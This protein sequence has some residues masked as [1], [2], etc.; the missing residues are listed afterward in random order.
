MPCRTSRQRTIRIEPV[1]GLFLIKSQHSSDVPI[2]SVSLRNF[3]RPFTFRA[4]LGIE[5]TPTASL[6][7]ISQFVGIFF[8]TKTRPRETENLSKNKKKNL[9]ASIRI[10]ITECM[11]ILIFFYENMFISCSPS[12]EKGYYSFVSAY[13]S[14]RWK[15]LYLFVFF[16][17]TRTWETE[18]WLK[19]KKKLFT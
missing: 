3:P 9:F 12:N 6:R 2:N 10:R 8:I 16:T 17:K 18:N 11:K 15:C 19:K 4:S 13:F 14:I 1:E 7:Q 5:T